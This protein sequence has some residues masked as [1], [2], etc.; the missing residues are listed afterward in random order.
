MEIRVT[1]NTSE[2][3]KRR[4]ILMPF[5]SFHR[6]L[7]PTRRLVWT[8]SNKPA[9][10]VPVEETGTYMPTRGT[11]LGYLTQFLP[12]SLDFGPRRSGDTSGARLQPPWRVW[13]NDD[14]AYIVTNQERNAFTR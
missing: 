2:R 12:A 6:H 10:A 5:S 3:I 14:I 7:L 13:L 8:V 1:V 9:I 4:L 11:C